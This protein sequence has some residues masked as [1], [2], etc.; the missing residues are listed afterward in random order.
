[1]PAI[2]FDNF[3][4]E[5][6]LYCHG[7]AKK[8]DG[9]G[10]IVFG[11]DSDAAKAWIAYAEDKG[12]PQR[13]CFFRK[14]LVQGN[15][16]TMPCADPARFDREYRPTNQKRDDFRPEFVSQ[17]PDDR[18]SVA[19]QVREIVA[20]SRPPVK[21]RRGDPEPEKPM[22][23]AEILAGLREKGAKEPVAMSPALASRLG[24]HP[25]DQAAE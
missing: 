7:Q 6:K 22:S 25:M 16:L 15:S 17:H 24:L 20:S 2:T 18:R 9:L 8:A 12:W 21:R 11:V 1:M 3:Y 14:M 4:E 19:A 13:A 10:L 23:H 5:V